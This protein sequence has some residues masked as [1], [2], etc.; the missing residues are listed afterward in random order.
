M[1]D[2]GGTWNIFG[3][4]KGLEPLLDHAGQLIA[5]EVSGHVF[6]G[7]EWTDHH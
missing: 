5:E 4:V 3:V 2:E 7:R 6:D 1:Y